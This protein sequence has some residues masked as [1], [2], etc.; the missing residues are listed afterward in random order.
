MLNFWMK[1]NAVAYSLYPLSAL[2]G[3]IS[4]LNILLRKRNAY[5][6]TSFVI[7]VGN[8]NV[9]GSGKTPLTIAIA[10]YL[11]SQGKKLL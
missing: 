8:I 2:Y 1:K 4:K 7:S 10:N 11:A 5:K 6:S 3:A 9:G